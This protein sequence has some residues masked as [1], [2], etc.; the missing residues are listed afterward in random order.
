MKTRGSS[1]AERRDSLPTMCGSIPTSA[2]IIGLCLVLTGC[3]AVPSQWKYRP[4]PAPQ[5]TPPVSETVKALNRPVDAVDASNRE[6]AG[7]LA[8]LRANAARATA[9]AMAAEARA[10][11][12]ATAG[13]ATKAELETAW[14]DWKTEH[15]TRNMFEELSASLETTNQRQAGELREV[16]TSLAEA[17]SSAA[18]SD[19]EKS[20]LRASLAEANSRGEQAQAVIDR[21]SA[22]ALKAEKQAANAMVYKRWVLWSV[23]ALIA[24]FALR[25]TKMTPWGR[26]W[27]FWLP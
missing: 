26:I 4:V 16:K 14:S 22:R 23:A 3:S 18:I 24:Y 12:L 6:L 11:T 21:E 5:P 27:L 17:A 2:L 25:I 1:T 13:T 15:Q 9:D 7:K 10:E 19:R 8:T 20:E